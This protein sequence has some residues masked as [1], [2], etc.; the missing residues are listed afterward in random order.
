MDSPKRYT[1][2]RQSENVKKGEGDES[3]RGDRV[4]KAGKHIQAENIK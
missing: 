4:E 3:T 1:S 2:A